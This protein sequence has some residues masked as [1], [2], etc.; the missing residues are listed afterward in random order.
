M[1]ISYSGSALDAMRWLLRT[2]T[3]AHGLRPGHVCGIA[4]EWVFHKV[5]PA[6]G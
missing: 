6:A 4:P 1:V 5:F 2:N 3:Q